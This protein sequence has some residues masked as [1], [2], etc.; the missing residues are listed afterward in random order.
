MP[1]DPSSREPN[2]LHE[3]LTEDGVTTLLLQW[4]DGRE[5]AAGRLVA[6]VYGELRQLASTRLRKERPDHTLQPT[7]LVNEVYL[8][9]QSR[10]QVDLRNRAQF[11]GFAGTLMRWI[12]VDHARSRL[13]EKRGRATEVLSLDVA[14]EPAAATHLEMEE[15]ITL[16]EALQRLQK[17][18]PRQVKVVDLHFFAGC[19]FRET[20]EILDIST[21]K[22]KREWAAAKTFL[23][24]ELTA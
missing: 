3:G 5:D 6:R 19:S 4:T 11:F 7:A 9:L 8:R 17:D 10:N 22:A 18:D 12:L 2:P 15:L 16:D 14:S 21:A 23:A 20:A 1:D 13:A 24:A